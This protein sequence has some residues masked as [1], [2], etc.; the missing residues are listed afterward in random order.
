MAVG[1]SKSFPKVAE[2][3]AFPPHSPFGIAIV[4]IAHQ[5][6]GLDRSVVFYGDRGEGKVFKTYDTYAAAQIDVLGEICAGTADTGFL[7]SAFHLGREAFFEGVAE[8]RCKTGSSFKIDPLTAGVR[9]TLRV[10]WE[11][12]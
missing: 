10:V 3:P 4:E 2:R 9:L 8:G 1:N 7:V 12:S 6:L 5:G 11:N